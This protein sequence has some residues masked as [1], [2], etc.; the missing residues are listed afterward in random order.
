MNDLRQPMTI[1][2]II[3]YLKEGSTIINIDKNSK[4]TYN[5]TSDIRAVNYK[6]LNIKVQIRK[7]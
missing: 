7:K 3:S 4:W 2:S 1:D 6:I 5:F